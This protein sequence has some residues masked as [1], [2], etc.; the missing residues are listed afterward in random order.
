[1]SDSIFS[2]DRRDEGVAIL[3]MNDPTD[4]INTFKIEMMDE[5]NQYLDE[6]ESSDIS[7]LI[8]ASGKQDNFLA[9][10]NLDM[11]KA[12]T[13]ANE[14][15]EISEIAQQFT[16][17]IENLDATTV[18]AIH[19]SCIGGG[20]ELA[21]AFDG[22]VATD[23]DKTRLGLPEVKL[24]VI[25]AGGGTQRLP[26][27]IGLERALD[28]VLTGRL[29]RPGHA[30]SWGVVDEVVHPDSLI[31][32]AIKLGR[33]HR[34]QTIN[35]R[36]WRDLI[37]RTR[38]W[39]MSGNSLGR[40]FIFNQARKQVQRKTRGNYPAPELIIKAME[41]GLNEGKE[42]GYHSE[43]AAFG[44]LVVSPQSRQLMNLFFASTELKKE[45]GVA[46][47]G[48]KP[49]EVNKIGILGAGLMGAGIAYV[50]INQA[51]IKTRIKDRDSE[52]V[53]RGLAYARKI[54]DGRVKKRAM[55][56][57]Q[58]TQVMNRLTGTRNYSGFQRCNLVIEAVFENLEL[59][60]QMVRDIEATCSDQTIFAS[61]T[62]ALPIHDIATAS[63]H[64][65]TIIGMHYFSP[66]EK[67]PLLEIIT[68]EQTADWVTATCVQLGHKQGK[69]VIV[70]K[71]GPGFYTTRILGPYINEA[72]YLL[73]EG[74]AIERI[75]KA[76]MDYGFPVGPMALLDEVGIDVGFHVADTLHHAFGERM[77][78]PTG[79]QQL[80]DDQRLGRKNNKG[81][82]CYNNNKTKGEKQPDESVYS[83]LGIKPDNVLDAATV[84]ERCA[85]QM[86]NEAAY[87][88][89][90]GILSSP[91]DGDIGAIFGLG[92]PPFLGGPFRTIDE[93]GPDQI[94][95]SLKKYQQ[96]HGQRFS[97]A[98]ILEEMANTKSRFY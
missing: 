2:L 22:R 81:L 60:Q 16:T 4:K 11:L 28:M 80:I 13:T 47:T 23:S 70:V 68:T 93:L 97:P 66:V 10:A 84:A 12:V 72:A 39:L 54:I 17:R 37:S 55:T 44:E 58:G 15:R 73:L 48:V 8:F 78:P 43:A 52:G 89:G 33:S 9:G 83:L 1:M 57:L 38:N 24:G 5:I 76:L 18:A 62:S 31:Q 25:P 45:S 59:K 56:R 94:L 26:R 88:L 14:A 92:F 30:L 50:S 77:V 65:E 74:V 96:I 3:W 87:C 49:V 63:R 6:V 42:Q 64:P 86:I 21:L 27:L 29:L 53:G 19:G 20:L 34:K 35:A 95:E 41:T 61:N 40:K 32:A 71:D 82:Y 75:D 7:V 69:T 91:R 79:L 67:M 36:N 51:A 85:L 90:E 46:D 98:P